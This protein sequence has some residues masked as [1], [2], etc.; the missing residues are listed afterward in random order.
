[1]ATNGIVT[2]TDSGLVYLPVLPF[3]KAQFIANIIVA[4]LVLVVVSVRVVGRRLGPGLGWD[5]GLPL[6][7]SLLAAQGLTLHLGSGYDQNQHPKVFF[8]VGYIIK[9]VFGMKL[10][11]VVTL[12]ATKAS[13]LCF[14]LRVF[15]VTNVARASKWLLGF[16]VVWALTFMLAPILICRP[17]SAHWTGLGKCGDLVPLIEW[18][19]ITNIASDLVIM[20]LP[21]PSIWSL[22]ARKTDKMSVMACFALGHAC[23]VCC[24]VRLIHTPAADAIEKLTATL[25]TTLFLLILEPN[26]AIICVSIPMLRPVYS[27]YRK[28][29][30]GSRLR[31]VSDKQ[32]TT[33]GGG[34]AAITCQNNT[35]DWEM[36]DY[37]PDMVAQHGTTVTA[38]VDD[39]GSEENLTNSEPVTRKDK[40]AIR[41]ETVWTMSRK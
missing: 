27:M 18:S 36:E 38:V 37:R 39:S 6:A 8:N 19:I 7:I 20:W 29:K 30:G 40:G 3:V 9:V 24:L 22:Q 41:V 33:S 21:M 12:A 2:P 31:E 16:C 10:V 1:M 11:Y 15:A 13:V 34:R 14:Y 4:I 32:T 5:D 35:I 17:V 25:P 23:V 28:R 26:I